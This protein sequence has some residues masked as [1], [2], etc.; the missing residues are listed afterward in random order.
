MCF[1]FTFMLWESP[2]QP[3]LILECAVIAWRIALQ[4]NKVL[5][6]WGRAYSRFGSH[7]GHHSFQEV[8]GVLGCEAPNSLLCCN[9]PQGRCFQCFGRF[10]HTLSSF[11]PLLVDWNFQASVAICP[12]YKC[13]HLAS[14]GQGKKYAVNS[15]SK[16]RDLYI[17]DQRQTSASAMRTLCLSR[18]SS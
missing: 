14:G 6:E 18:A 16:G 7:L 12:I 10:T 11:S 1:L 9:G 17:W 2:W 8:S 5:F 15:K 4:A 3:F 13:Q